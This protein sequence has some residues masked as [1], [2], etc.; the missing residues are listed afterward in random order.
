MALA[1]NEK[2]IWQFH[3][4]HETGGFEKCCWKVRLCSCRVENCVPVMSR[5]GAFFRLSTLDTEDGFHCPH[6]DTDDELFITMKMMAL[7][8]DFYYGASFPSETWQ[9]TTFGALVEGA[10][11]GPRFGAD[12]SVISSSSQ[13]LR[14]VM[15]LRLSP[16]A[17][18]RRSQ[19]RSISS[20]TQNA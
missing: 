13:R 18:V 20:H 7:W 9:S 15:F 3:W 12:G 11:Q 5:F 10:P 2:I 16:K 1:S 6:G 8:N 4:K 14:T 19:M 17:G